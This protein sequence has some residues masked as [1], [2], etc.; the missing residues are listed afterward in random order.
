[1]QPKS[2]YDELIRLSRD[3]ATLASCLDV[4]EWD[5]ETVLPRGG[6]D[7]RSEQLALLA[8]YWIEVHRG[9]AK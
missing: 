6:I 5:E 7:H 8:R 2:A 3:E 1:M 4:L 9:G